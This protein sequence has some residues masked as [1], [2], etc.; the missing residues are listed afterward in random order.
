V[1]EDRTKT[2]RHYTVPEA[3][4]L[5]GLTVEAVRG[6][7]KRNKLR[8]SKEDGTVYVYLDIDQIPTSQQPD[9]DQTA[10][11]TELVE[12][13]KDQLAYMRDQLEA[14]REANRENRRIIAAL[15]SRIPEL[16]PPA[17]EEPSEA[18]EAPE[19][20]TE[21]P[22]RVGPQAPLEE[23]QEGAEAPRRRSWWREFFGFD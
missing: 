16:S 10:A 9:E 21:Q 12:V 22:G 1:G 11:P 13:L 6:R 4:E 14:E 2:G 3:A 7:I 18:T 15:T 23:A 19:T 17:Q 20:A 5:L 8:S